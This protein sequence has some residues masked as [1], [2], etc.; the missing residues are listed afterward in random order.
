MVKKV[1]SWS[2]PCSDGF[3]NAWSSYSHCLAHLCDMVIKWAHWQQYLTWDL[4]FLWRC[5]W[6]L[7]SSGMWCCVIDGEVPQFLM[8]LLFPFSQSARKTKT[9]CF[10]EEVVY[11]YQSSW[12]HILEFSVF[13]CSYLGILLGCAPLWLS[14][15]VTEIFHCVSQIV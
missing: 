4:G 15:V 9:A 8:K 3:E 14:A 11:I 6:W 10:S 13:R 5:T 12:C 1:C 2:S 7:L